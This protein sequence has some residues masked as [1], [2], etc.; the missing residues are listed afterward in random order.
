MKIEDHYKNLNESLTVIRDCIRKGVE[1]YQRSIGFHVSVALCD[2]LEIY[3]H[4]NN[5]IDPGSVIKHDFF[6]SR[7][8][9]N[10]RLPEFEDK[11]KIISLLA[12]IDEKR[13]ILCYGKRQV[14]EN[15]AEFLERFHSLKKIFEDRGVRIE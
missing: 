11:E 5:L 9:A 4:D 10:E 13:N 1:N 15:L 14:K 6:A 12:E 7:R 3:L 8:K 2:M